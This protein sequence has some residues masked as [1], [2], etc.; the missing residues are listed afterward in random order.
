MR[1]TMSFTER[2]R[3][4]MSDHKPDSEADAQQASFSDTPVQRLDQAIESAK[5][6]AEAATGSKDAIGI[7]D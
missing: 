5:R 3:R 7:A 4:A 2:R 6:G 1:N